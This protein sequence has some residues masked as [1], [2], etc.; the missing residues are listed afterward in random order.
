[1]KLEIYIYMYIYTHANII[2]FFFA[3]IYSVM[4]SNP[5]PYLAIRHGLDLHATRNPILSWT[6]PIGPHQDNK[7]RF[8]Y[9]IRDAM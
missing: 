7:I 3:C 8:Y 6:W 9:E 1:L 4:R 2:L 5:H